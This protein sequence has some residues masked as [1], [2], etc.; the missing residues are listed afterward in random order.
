MLAFTSFAHST[1]SDNQTKGYQFS[2]QLPRYD[3]LGPILPEKYAPPK[4]ASS[5]STVLAPPEVPPARLRHPDLSH[6]QELSSSVDDYHR[7]GSSFLRGS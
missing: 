1:A 7:I 2:E 4:A 6:Q 3:G 5:V